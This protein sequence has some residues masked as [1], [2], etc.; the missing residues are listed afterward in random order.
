LILIFVTGGTGLV[1]SRLLYVLLKRGKE[2]HALARKESNTAY[3]KKVFSYYSDQ[4]SELF[5][6]IIWHE[7]DVTQ[8]DSLLMEM[9]GM[10]EVYHT[11]AFVS[12]QP[13]DKQKIFAVNHRGTENVLNAALENK[14]RKFCHVS[15]VA[16]LGHSVDG[17]PINEESEWDFE[18]DKSDY[19]VSKFLA[20]MEVNRAIEEGLSA[21]IVNPVVILGSGFWS[22]GSSSFFRHVY[23]G[24]KYYT[25]GTNGY[26]DVRDVVD[27]MLHLM[28]NN[29]FNE[30]FVLSS[31]C[32]SYKEI[33]MQIADNLKVKPPNKR[34][35]SSMLNLAWRL[36][37]LK[38][39]LTGKQPK[40][41]RKS[42]K[43]A[44]ENLIYSNRKVLDQLNYSFVPVNDTIK[45]IGDIFL[46]DKA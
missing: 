7:G 8:P 4:A 1:G 27:I 43:S 10:E 29:C 25:E 34:V 45:F 13:S 22:R 3:V 28:D 17:S 12:F 42:A 41:T 46:K 40:I 21:V 37:S 39:T 32:I 31:Q 35:T 5:D 44:E 2:V 26:V 30:R 23:K 24:M 18:L 11:A 38:S 36:E 16:A 19:A 6:R 14:V 33:L 20:E 9:E 15:S